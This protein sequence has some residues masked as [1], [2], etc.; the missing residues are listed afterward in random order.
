MMTIYSY[1]CLKTFKN[2]PLQYKFQ[3]IDKIKREEERIELFLGSRFH[4][5]ME[6]IYKDLILR[7]YSLEELLVFYQEDW[8]QNYHDKIIITDKERKVEDY[9]KIGRKY[10]EDY[11]QHYYPFN[12]GKILGLE[13]EVLINL[14]DDGQEYRLRGIIDRLEQAKDGTYEIHDYKTSK[15]FPEQIK[16]D[17]DHQLALY[18]LGIQRMWKDVHQVELV[19]HYVA[20]DKEIRSVRSKEELE[21]LKKDT[22][23]WI[24]KI[25]T[26]PEFLPQ[27]SALCGWC[28]YQD[29]CPLF[30]HESIVKDLSVNEY[31]KDNG[32]QL[33][34]KFM[35][36]A[37][38]KKSYQA[39]IKELEEKLEQIKEAVI[40]YAA[41]LGVAVVT[42]S[43]HQLKIHSSEKILV[44]GKGTKERE[45]LIELLSQLN[46]L[47]EVSSF[48]VAELKKVI[49]E[50]KWDSAI[51]D[52]V[53][54]FVE[55]ETIKSVSL[56]KSIREK[57]G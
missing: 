40:Q 28:S 33:V 2:C 27:E 15:T 34:N 18:Q 53:K 20:F 1:S 17:E 57:T 47:E 14:E 51:L 12:Q 43:D 30:K 32:V 46:R 7:R 10:I 29:I 5:V 19:W 23:R 21:E 42:G 24:K 4:K 3:Y 31:L 45:S 52:E 44:P 36:L 11:Y 26:T 35:L 8:D 48:D 55:I 49:K 54:K 50:K 25:E 16:M 38:K 39:K 56:S 37:N 22:V 13:R 6:K 41:Q 9:Q